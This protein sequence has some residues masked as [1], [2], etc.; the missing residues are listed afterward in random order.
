[1][2]RSGELEAGSK[3]EL[4]TVALVDDADAAGDYTLSLVVNDGERDSREDRVT[5]TASTANSAPVA[6]AGPDRNV[7]V[8]E[9]AT[10]DGRGSSD[11][12]DDDLSYDWR[13]VSRPDDSAASLA[14]LATCGGIDLLML[15][16]A[17]GDA[18]SIRGQWRGLEEQQIGRLG[19]ANF[20]LEQLDAARA[21]LQGLQDGTFCRQFQEMLAWGSPYAHAGPAGKRGEPLRGGHK[22][23]AAPLLYAPHRG[24]A[25]SCA[26]P[27]FLPPTCATTASIATNAVRP[28]RFAQLRQVEE[29]G[30]ATRWNW[31]LGA[32]EAAYGAYREFQV[33]RIPKA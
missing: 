17:G 25:T 24:H 12:D 32:L 7:S 30:P 14:D 11:A 1:M 9:T 33:R 4:E 22:N 29:G 19:V 15:E 21:Q 31:W 27:L 23:P 16:R 10:L 6:D 2:P 28:M 8:N 18:E 3:D 26:P 5:V 13:I 20:D